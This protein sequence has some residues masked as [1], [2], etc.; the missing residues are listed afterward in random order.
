MTCNELQNGHGHL[1][2]GKKRPRSLVEKLKSSRSNLTS[3]V[4][5]LDIRCRSTVVLYMY[6]IALENC[7]R[8]VRLVK[9]TAR[10]PD[11]YAAKD[12]TVLSALLA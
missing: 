3:A 10:R 7:A 5:V 9:P 4:L 12:E 6:V 11:N 8:C 1:S 2:N